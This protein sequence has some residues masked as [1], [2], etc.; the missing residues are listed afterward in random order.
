MIRNFVSLLCF[1][2]SDYLAAGLAP[3]E[4]SDRSVRSRGASPAASWV[5]AIVALIVFCTF[6]INAAPRPNILIILADDM[7]YS[8]IGCFG[9]EIQ[10]PNLDALAKN[11]VRL[12]QFYNT[13]RCCPT[14]ASLMT[15]LYPHQAGVGHMTWKAEGLPGYMGDLSKS[16]PTIAEVLHTAGY[17]TYMCGKWHITINDQPN[18]PHENW[19]PQRGFDRFYGTIKGGGSYYDPPMLVRD[20]K[21]I[22]PWADPEYKPEHYYYTDALGDQAIRYLTEHS[23]QNKDKPFFMYLA[24]TSPHWPLH[25]PA[26]TIE[27]YKGKYDGGYE[28][29][30]AARY[31]KL[32]ELGIIDPN[33]ALSDAPEAWSAVKH[34]EWES[35]NM[36]VYAAQVDRMDQNIGR[37]VESLKKNGQLDNTLILF[38]SDNGGCAENTGR[39]DNSKKIAQ[40]NPPKRSAE[41]P[42]TVT[43][44]LFTRDGRPIRSGPKVQAGPDDSYIAYG[45]DW[46]NVSNTPFR[47][48]KH[49]N[50]EGGISAPFIAYWPKGIDGHGQLEKQPAHL[51][52]VMATCIDLSGAKFPTE[53]NGEKTTELHGVSLMREFKGES[54]NRPTP[55]FWEHEG[56]RAIREGNWKLV[57]LGAE[58]AWELYD[59]DK[60]RTE[61]HDLAKEQ[62]DRVKE[63][64]EKWQKWA[65]ASQ[66]LP[67]NPRKDAMKSGAE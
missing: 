37:V 7:G 46:A 59:M 42:A 45:R 61:L 13:G 2:D 67:L 34:H 35:H 39:F 1:E 48:Y 50:H 28:P 31:N 51:I 54:L 57:A 8:D 47:M 27:K 3:R 26:D 32:K 38:F 19:P 5:G 60:D 12:T 29:I 20:M 22:T 36:E 44:P 21:I 58:G 23:Q 18:K 62:P 15:G 63:M 14:R 43:A 16:T 55:L 25:A 11:G 9:S 4:I 30:R 40:A 53:F 6:A 65:E 56:N 33:W 52:D 41:T 66:V 64:S 49:Y 10:T 17:S 24:F